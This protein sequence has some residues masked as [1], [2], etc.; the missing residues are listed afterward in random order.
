MMTEKLRELLERLV[1][2]RAI[3]W[4]RVL[5]EVSHGDER[6]ALE[7][8]HGLARFTESEDARDDIDLRAERTVGVP[9]PSSDG[10]PRRWGHLEVLEEIGRGTYGVVYR[11]WDTRLARHVALKLLS[12]DEGGHSIDEARRLARVSHP[13]VVSVY[14]ADRID[15]TVGVWMELLGGRTL[16][17]I[18]KDVGPLS[19]R[20]ACG[21]G[22]D[23]CGAVAA[24]HAA[25]L[26]H[27]D[28]KAQNVM[29]ERGG[30]LVLMDVGAS[31]ALSESTAPAVSFTGTPLYMSP[32]LF[33]GTGP[34]VASDVY[35]IGV[36]L[37]RLVTAE[38]PIEG[39][40]LGDVRRAHAESRRRPLRA[41]RPDL[42]PDS[43]AS[44]SGAWRESPR[45]GTPLLPHSSSRFTTPAARNLLSP[46]GC[47]EHS[48]GHCLP[49]LLH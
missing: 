45:R 33:D 48:L 1:D 24:I 38:F 3:D 43:Y 13:H 11:A 36:L 8:L 31:I 10:P 35:A 4:E 22:I 26:I 42:G 21:V 23:V 15:G 30:R 49:P 5:R 46:E 25:G 2:G 18:L 19:E 47:T 37:Y 6:A 9:A 7:D 17:A 29:R 16:D 39:Q 28:I 27:R 20:E 14:G 44:S 40:T 41:V 12:D 34:S 32:E